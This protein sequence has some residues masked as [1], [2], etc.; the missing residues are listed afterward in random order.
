M[1]IKL[2]IEVVNQKKERKNQKEVGLRFTEAEPITKDLFF[3]FKI[4]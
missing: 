1:K 3:L 2:S 4:I